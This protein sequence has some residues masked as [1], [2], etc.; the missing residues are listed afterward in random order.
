MDARCFTVVFPAN[1]SMALDQAHAAAVSQSA[2]AG[3][4]Q[5]RRTESHEPFF[6]S[7]RREGASWP[8]SAA[9]DL[10]CRGVFLRVYRE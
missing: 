1:C 4:D 5:Q 7:G 6:Q 8:T 9:V 2:E 10:H 3:R